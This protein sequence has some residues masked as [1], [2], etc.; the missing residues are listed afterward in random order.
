[1]RLLRT[2]RGHTVKTIEENKL[3]LLIWSCEP[4]KCLLLTM[5][6]YVVYFEDNQIQSGYR[7]FHI[8]GP[9]E[10]NLKCRHFCQF[11][12]KLQ[13]TV[14]HSRSILHTH[15]YYPTVSLYDCIRACRTVYLILTYCVSESVVLCIWSCRTV[16]PNLSYFVSEPDV[17]CIRT[18]RTVYLILY[19][20]YSKDP[21]VHLPNA[22]RYG[23][24]AAGVFVIGSGEIIVEAYWKKPSMKF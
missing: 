9:I 1:M 6:T 17:L 23:T 18:C 4:N 12:Q 22:A 3:Y 16:Y 10:E 20:E 5:L 7:V 21:I 14:V 24:S 2:L 13:R 8:W 11:C 15:I 19:I